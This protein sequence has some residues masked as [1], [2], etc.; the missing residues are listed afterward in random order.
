MGSPKEPTRE[1]TVD[2]CRY[3]QPKKTE[4]QIYADANGNITLQLPQTENQVDLIK[5][6]LI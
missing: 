4:M 6:S 1:Q 5:V 3:A 2:L